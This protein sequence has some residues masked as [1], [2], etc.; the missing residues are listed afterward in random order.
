MAETITIRTS[1]ATDVIKVIA[2]GPQGPAGPAGEGGG[3]PEG[4][5]AGQMLRKVS[6]TDYDT[7]WSSRVTSLEAVSTTDITG[8]LGLQVQC[9]TGGGLSAV[10]M[11]GTV[12]AGSPQARI[13]AAGT[14]GSITSI[15]SFSASGATINTGTLKL[16][17]PTGGETAEFS[18]ADLSANRTYTLTNDTGRLPALQVVSSSLTPYPYSP[19]VVGQFVFASTGH[20]YF[21]FAANRWRRVLLAKQPPA[22]PCCAPRES[23]S[24][25]RCS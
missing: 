5:T 10:G 3:A 13:Y 11:L 18:A 19:G 2:Q 12:V 15:A 22:R 9:P 16:T 6:S 4:G 24:A 25:W 7:E 23:K 21:C 20:F 1:S 14:A 8:S 17:D